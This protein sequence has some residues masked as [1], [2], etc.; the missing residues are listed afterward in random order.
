[1]VKLEN[2]GEALITWSITSSMGSP[3]K[4]PAQPTPTFTQTSHIKSGAETPLC[5]SSFLKVV[6]TG[7]PCSFPL[8]QE[9]EIR[10]HVCVQ[11]ELNV[12]LWP[13]KSRGML[14]GRE[15]PADMWVFACEPWKIS[16]LSCLLRQVSPYKHPDG[17]NNDAECTW[18][19]PC[20]TPGKTCLEK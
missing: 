7:K 15:I 20:L 2:A 3:D 17:C 10:C 4:S 6:V 1:M 12:F 18:V 14:E 5:V 8:F 11:A 9:T 16:N 13:D 19:N